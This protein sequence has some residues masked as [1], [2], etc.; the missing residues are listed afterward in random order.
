[1]DERDRFASDVIPPRTRLTPG[2]VLGNALLA[3]VVISGLVGALILAGPALDA[4][5]HPRP[6]GPEAAENR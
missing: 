6:E 3:L 2:R 1:M 4:E 5:N